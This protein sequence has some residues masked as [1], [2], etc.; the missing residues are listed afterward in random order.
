MVLISLAAV[1]GGLAAIAA[2]TIAILAS[3]AALRD[4]E[5]M[6]RWSAFFGMKLDFEK[7]HA[8][9]TGARLMIPPVLLIWGGLMIIYG[10]SLL[11]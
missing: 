2:G 7:Y 6:K 1:V 9:H 10:I 5:W 3:I 11:T 4:R 8:G